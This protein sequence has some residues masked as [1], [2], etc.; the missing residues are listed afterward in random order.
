MICLTTFFLTLTPIARALPRGCHD[1]ISPE[2]DTNQH[3]FAYG[4]TLP[5]PILSPLKAT[6]DQRFDNPG[7]LFN[8]VACS[9]GHFSGL[10]SRVYFCYNFTLVL[11]SFQ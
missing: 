3:D 1:L 5:D 7:G 11:A 6:Y 4:D 10:F 9:N 8:N 2:T